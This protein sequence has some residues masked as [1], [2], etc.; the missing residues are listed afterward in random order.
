MGRPVDWQTAERW[1]ERLGA[2]S[3]ETNATR[4]SGSAFIAPDGT[5][6]SLPRMGHR[7]VATGEAIPVGRDRGTRGQ[8]GERTL[9]PGWGDGVSLK[10]LELWGL[11]AGRASSRNSVA[12][13][14]GE[15]I[16]SQPFPR[17]SRRPKRRRFTRGYTPPP[18][19]GRKNRESR[20][21]NSQP[22]VDRTPERDVQ[23]PSGQ[24]GQKNE[25]ESRRTQL[26]IGSFIGT[27][28]A[29]TVRD[30]G[31]DRIGHGHGILRCKPRTSRQ[32]NRLPVRGG[33]AVQT[34]SA[35]FRIPRPKPIFLLPASA[36]PP[37][38]IVAPRVQSAC[39]RPHLRVV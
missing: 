14:R 15:R 19:P 2:R 3:G 30:S 22:G 8:K 18:A 24:A 37:C 34:F 6:N 39:F 33:N 20:L 38:K 32:P 13:V 28:P 4:G 27:T 36:P 26:P 11:V 35:I 23:I 17:V 9:R 7:I 29:E 21:F 12:L 1:R 31:I 10:V 5:T 16:K 25:T